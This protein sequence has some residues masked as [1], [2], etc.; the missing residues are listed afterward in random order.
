MELQSRYRD[1]TAQGIGV[2]AVS[3]DSIGTLK[4]F[5]GS[6][7]ITFPLV[8]DTGSAIIRRYGLLN[9]TLDPKTRF[10]GVPHPGTFMLDA[11]GVVLARYFEDAYQERTTVNSIL[12]RQLDPK[13]PPNAV[14]SDTMHLT[15]Q[16][17]ISD[18][19]VA[20]GK[21]IS[22]VFDVKPKRNMHVYAPGRHDYQVIAARLDP[23]PWLKV[24]PP[25]YPASE[26]YHFK[27]LNERV[28]T[29]G[30]AFRL[31]QDVTVLATQEV[32]KQL[33]TTPTITLSG[34]LEYQAC[35]DKVCYAPTSVPIRFTLTVQELDRKPAG[36]GL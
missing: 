32:Q 6:R 16:T 27:E 34:S 9:E 10:Y 36:G 3:Y 8:S 30:K 20:P 14:R 26:I 11:K 23:Q 28:A 25:R 1:L 2:V 22:L 18:T 21:R 15:L 13:A 35:D 12:A 33:A 7:G 19:S 17:S 29:Y 4:R 5:A 31:V 24:M